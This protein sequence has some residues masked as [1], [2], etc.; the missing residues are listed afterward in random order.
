MLYS[1]ESLKW[2]IFSTLNKNSRFYFNFTINWIRKHKNTEFWTIMNTTILCFN[3]FSFEGGS[4]LTHHDIRNTSPLF[5]RRNRSL[6][7]Q[8]LQ[9]QLVLTFFVCFLTLIKNWYLVIIMKLLSSFH[10]I[11]LWLWPPKFP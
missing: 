5:Q 1:C 2:K 10:K 4:S 9:C 3:L 11:P 8:F 7:L 6:N